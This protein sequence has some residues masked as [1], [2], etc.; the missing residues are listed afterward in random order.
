MTTNQNINDL[1]EIQ[2]KFP[3]LD[4][5]VKYLDKSQ[6]IE[7][8]QKNIDVPIM[9][10]SQL[11]LRLQKLV[12]APDQPVSCTSGSTGMPVV[13][14]KTPESTMWHMATNIRD[15]K[16]RKWDLTK[17]RVAI[18]ARFDSDVE[19]ENVYLKRLDSVQNLQLY[20]NRVQPQY[21]YTYPSIIKKLDLTLLTELC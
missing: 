21:L 10:K 7:F 15:F 2:I 19:H 9:T 4:D 13:I 16:W 1:P 14:P 6:Y 20:L 8:R 18:L 5:L 11:Q 12:I 3:L 17:K